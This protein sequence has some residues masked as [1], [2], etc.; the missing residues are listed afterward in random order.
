M[1]GSR[2]SLPTLSRICLTQLTGSKHKGSHMLVPTS[3]LLW[4]TEDSIYTKVEKSKRKD[5]AGVGYVRPWKDQWRPGSSHDN[6]IRHN[7]TEQLHSMH[8]LTS[9]KSTTLGFRV[10]A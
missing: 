6:T 10:W 7:Q 2:N 5:Y 3:L 8:K 4:H 9:S 1:D